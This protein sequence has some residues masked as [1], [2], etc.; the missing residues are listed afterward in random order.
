MCF[1]LDQT[2]ELK[3]ATRKIT[4]WKTVYS[5][6]NRFFSSVKN[7]EYIPGVRQPEVE[8][9]MQKNSIYN[10][11]HSFQRKRLAREDSTNSEKSIVKFY[12]PKGSKYYM[13]KC[14]EIVSS[15]IVMCKKIY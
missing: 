2:S 8:L 7:Y 5:R 12:I 14:G 13:N 11:Y 15:S 4:C 1:Q 10:G 9:C 3:I 6:K